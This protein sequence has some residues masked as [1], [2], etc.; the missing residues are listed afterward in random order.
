MLP[1]IH[2]DVAFLAVATAGGSLGLLTTALVLGFRHGI[3]WDHIAAITDITS[4]TA[5]ADAGEEA[6]EVEHRAMRELVSGHAH[7][8][9]GPS[10]LHAHDL[11]P[12]AATLTL[13]PETLSMRHEAQVRAR[14]RGLIREQRHAIL[15]GTLYALGHAT[16]V[17]ALG[18]AALLF[19]A[20]LPGWV[21]P[22]MGRVVGLTLVFLGVWVYVSLYQ[23]LRYGAEFRLRSR[24]MLVFA[25][26]RG[27]WR[28]LQARLHG[29]EHVAPIEMSSYGPRTAFGVGM[30]HGIGAE[31]GTQVLLIAAIGGASGAGLGIP[32]MI[33]FIVGLL[34]ANTI[35]V[36][37]TASG[38]TASRFR[39]PI[40]LGIG[41]LAGSFSLVIGLLFLFQAEGLLPEINRILG[42]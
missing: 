14:P 32:M 17:A 33:A 18:F 40:Y 10:E 22:I 23:Y 35:I 34:V 15:L 38:F 7:E 1:A 28:R 30:I 24:W 25:A 20:V 36:I 27:S 39:Q 19:G 37:L 11:G 16:V 5:S 26:I 3:D 41:V 6:H 21:D 8:H 42:T 12:G 4:S 2:L 31:T 9:G 13:R 29:H